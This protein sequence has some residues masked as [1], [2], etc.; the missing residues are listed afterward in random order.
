MAVGS[1]R[2]G[3]RLVTPEDLEAAYNALTDAGE[4]LA[5]IGVDI[6]PVVAMRSEL[7]RALGRVPRS[8]WRWRPFGPALRAAVDRLD[9]E[10][11][12]AFDRLAG[13]ET[14]LGETGRPGEALA[15]RHIRDGLG[16]AI[17][18]LARLRL[19]LVA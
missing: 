14:V 1:P 13:L 18:R 2:A 5:A 12:V 17:G 16:E 9:R 4:Q 3:G 7:A 10:L 19:R 8:Y 15:A 11:G 6:A